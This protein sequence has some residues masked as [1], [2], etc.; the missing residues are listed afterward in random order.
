MIRVRDA[1]EVPRM[2]PRVSQTEQLNSS[3][4]L[5]IAAFQ[6]RDSDAYASAGQ[7]LVEVAQQASPEELDAAVGGLLPVIA[8]IH[9]SGG[10][11]LAQLVGSM[12][13]TSGTS[14]PTVVPVLVERACEVMED[15]LAFVASYRE[16]FG[17]EPD[18][19]DGT[20]VERY[21][22]AAEARG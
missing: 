3:I 13:G 2:L 20:G 14:A 8:D 18:R 9:T 4:D 10:A 17:A 21:L 11:G 19:D 15:V 7:Q 6:D 12:V 16:Y 5:L 22:Q 1:R